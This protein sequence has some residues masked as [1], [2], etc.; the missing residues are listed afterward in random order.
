MYV[1]SWIYCFPQVYWVIYYNELKTL[2]NKFVF[3]QKIISKTSATT[4][5]K[6]CAKWLRIL[7]EI[8]NYAYYF[9]EFS[10]SFLQITLLSEA[11]CIRTKSAFIILCIISG[12]DEGQIKLHC[13]GI[14]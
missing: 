9:N 6:I 13:R 11:Q 8:W 1:I 7:F 3:A 12:K 10:T 14:S 4:P 2:K 5:W